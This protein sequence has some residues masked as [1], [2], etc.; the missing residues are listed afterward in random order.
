ME[1]QVGTRIKA[2]DRISNSLIVV[3]VCFFLK[4][5]NTRFHQRNHLVW[6]DCDLYQKNLI[7]HI[8]DR[9][10]WITNLIFTCFV[11]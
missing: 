9:Q 7:G 1:A 10:P 11:T 8:R 4:I 5:E 3:P 2:Y 6:G